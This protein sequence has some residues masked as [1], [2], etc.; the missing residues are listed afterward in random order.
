VG[1]LLRG[2]SRNEEAHCLRCLQTFAGD[3]ATARLEKHRSE[4]RSI[5]GGSVQ[6]VTMPSAEDGKNILEFGD[7][8]KTLRAPFAIYLDFESSLVAAGD[9]EQPKSCKKSRLKG[10]APNTERLQSHVTNSYHFVTIGS[11]GKRWL[12]GEYDGFYRGPSAA[13]HCLEM[14]SEVGT[15]LKDTLQEH[16]ECP[17]RTREQEA[18]FR[19]AEV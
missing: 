1:R 11:D 12:D 6:R 4:C 9:D 10:E 14:L 8:E 16:R 2:I 18:A 7:Y 15:M 5:N 3:G 19:A 13:K 17:R